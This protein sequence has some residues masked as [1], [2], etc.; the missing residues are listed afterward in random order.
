MP[1]TLKYRFGPFEA[2][3]NAAELYRGGTR[4]RLQMQPFQVLVALLE[5]PREVVAREDL[6]LR[7][8]PQ[9]TFVDFDHGLNTAMAKLRDVLGDSASHPSYIE[10]IAK[11]GY[12]FLGEVEKVQEPAA[13]PDVAV[14]S[15]TAATVAVSSVPAGPSRAPTAETEL[16]RAGRGTSRLLFVLAQIMYLIF[17][18]SALYDWKQLDRAASA[19]WP[20]GGLA[21]FVVYLVTALVGVVVRLYLITATAFD[22]H[23]LGEKYRIL[24]PALFVLDMIWA[25]APCLLADR[26][27]WGLALGASAALIYMPFA[28]RVLMKMIQ[29]AA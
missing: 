25:L 13:G 29:R 19:I 14:S 24:F 7:L 23:L 26:M 16:P 1:A 3:I 17:Y 22:Y 11:R 21:L 15:S 8:W 6:R 10:T 12:R 4:L 28:Q 27:G 20:G 9:D 18:F 2:D 5:R